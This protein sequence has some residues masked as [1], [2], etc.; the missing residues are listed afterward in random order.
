[1]HRCSRE[2]R[3]SNLTEFTLR[4]RGLISGVVK[5]EAIVSKLPFGFLWGIDAESGVVVDDMS[6]LKGQALTGKVFVFPHGRGSTGGS[7]ILLEAARRRVAPLAILNRNAEPIVLSGALLAD[8]MYH[9][10]I[11][12]VDRLD[13]NPDEVIET[14]DLVYVDGTE[15]LVVVS[16]SS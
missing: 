2:R 15:G 5:G 11:P 7:G 13:R 6:P 4:G 16:R 3:V 9:V 12:I 10:K 14:G 8:E 1:M